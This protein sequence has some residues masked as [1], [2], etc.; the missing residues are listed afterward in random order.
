[1]TIDISAFSFDLQ[2][3]AP[4]GAAG[5]VMH[6]PSG[7]AAKLP[8]L[9]AYRQG[10]N[11]PAYFGNNWDAVA[12]CLRDLSWIDQHRIVII[13]ADLP[14]LSGPYKRVYLE[15]LADSVKSWE[16]EGGHELNVVFPSSCRAAIL[17]VSEK[18]K[19]RA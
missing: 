13:H 8:L 6:V 16:P 14:G 19:I 4:D 2:P 10:L 12:D 15:I 5:F 7:L 1:M 3:A 9:E 18:S 11:F 17:D